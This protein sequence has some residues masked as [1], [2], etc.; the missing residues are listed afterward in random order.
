MYIY[1]NLAVESSEYLNN[2]TKQMNLAKGKKK[3]M[4]NNKENSNKILT[5]NNIK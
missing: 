3:D 4:R 1:K 2:F 5:L